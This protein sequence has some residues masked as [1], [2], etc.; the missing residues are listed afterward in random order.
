MSDRIWFSIQLGVA[1]RRLRNPYLKLPP[2]SFSA[3]IDALTSLISFSFTLND[4]GREGE[5]RRVKNEWQLVSCLTQLQGL[6]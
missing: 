4:W 5:R 6:L 2:N 3:W 1:L